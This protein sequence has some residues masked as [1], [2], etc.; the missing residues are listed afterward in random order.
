MKSIKSLFGVLAFALALVLSFA[1]KPSAKPY[2]VAYLQ[3]GGCATA[4]T[5]NGGSHA[6]KIGTAPAFT[7]ITTCVNAAKMP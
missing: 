4:V 6:C 7:D 3:A 1:F 2:G 5:C